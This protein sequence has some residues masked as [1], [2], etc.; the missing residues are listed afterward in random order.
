MRRGFLGLQPS[1]L[2]P[3]AIHD[4]PFA[5]GLAARLAQVNLGSGDEGGGAVAADSWQVMQGHIQRRAFRPVI[6]SLGVRMDAKAHELLPGRQHLDSRHCAIQDLE[7][8]GL[9]LVEGH[10]GAEGQQDLRRA[11]DTG[12]G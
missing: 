4:A 3:L 5:G 11:P 12:Q 9:H 8:A 1:E 6:G 7:F 2:A 10:I